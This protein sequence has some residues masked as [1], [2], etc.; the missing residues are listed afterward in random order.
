MACGRSPR[1]P[2]GSPATSRRTTSSSR[3]PARI[4]PIPDLPAAF[5]DATADATPELRAEGARAVIGAADEAGVDRLRLV[6]DDGRVDRGGELA[7]DPVRRL[8]DDF[9]ADRRG[10]GSRAAAPATPRRRRSTRRRSMP[11]RS[12]ARPRPRPGQPRTRSA[13]SRATIRSSSRR[14]PWSTSSTCSATSGSAPWPS[15][16]AGRSPS[17][18]AGWAASSSTSGTTAAD[19]LGLPMAFDFEGVAKQRVSLIEG[20]ICR[21]VVYDAQTAA[22]D[23][24]RSTGH[25]LPAPNPYGPFPL[26]MVMGSRNGLA[27]RAHRRARARICSS[28]GSTT[29]TRSIRSWP[30]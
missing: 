9:P 1:P 6:R 7:R 24:V 26:N 12:G 20:G 17:R 19:P 25:G 5:A 16:R 11:R 30:S 28:P 13:S 15:R 14:T 22:R 21:D 10:D 23:G 4:G 2:G 8:A 27:R 18:A 3:C 29:R